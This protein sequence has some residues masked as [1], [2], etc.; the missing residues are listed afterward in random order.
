MFACQRIRQGLLGCCET[1]GQ[2]RPV[3]ILL[4]AHAGISS[5][6]GPCEVSASAQARGWWFTLFVA[7]TLPSDPSPCEPYSSGCRAARSSLLASLR[8]YRVK[9]AC[10][11]RVD[12]SRLVLCVSGGYLLFCFMPLLLL[13]ARKSQDPRQKKIW[14][15]L[16]HHNLLTEH[17][18]SSR[19]VQCDE[20]FTANNRN[21]RSNRCP[22]SCSWSMRPERRRG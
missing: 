21:R 6:S 22:S 18:A 5:S 15:G 13:L 14:T 2:P 8:S 7:C 1:C 19:R 17:G 16:C 20:T 9:S 3:G 10:D 4:Q 12:G 11:Y